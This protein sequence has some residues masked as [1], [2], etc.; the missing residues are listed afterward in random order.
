MYEELKKDDQQNLINFSSAT[1][2]FTFEGFF[3]IILTMIK[4]NQLFVFIF[5]TLFMFLFFGCNLPEKTTASNESQNKQAELLI[6]DLV[7]TA[8]AEDPYIPQAEGT[9]NEG[10]VVPDSPVSENPEAETP[11]IPSEPT[12]VPTPTRDPNRKPPELPAVFQTDLLHKLDTPHE[13]ESEICRV[14]KN[15]W[16]EGKAAPGTVVMAIMYH[17]IIRGEDTSSIS[18]PILRANTVTIDQHKQLIRNLHDQG[19]TAINTEQ[20]IAF[21]E[22]NEWI[23]ERSVLLIQDDRRHEDNFLEHFKPYYDEWGWQVINGWISAD[24][25]TQ[26]LWDENAR[27]EELGLVD[28][29][30][31]GVVHNINMG[32]DSSDEFLIGELKGSV[33][34]IQEHFHKT[35]RAIIWPGGGFGAR[36]IEIAKEYGYKVGFTTH[37]RGP[38]MYNWVPLC[39]VNDMGRPAYKMDGNMDPLFVIPRYWNTDASQHVDTVRQIGKAAQEYYYSIRETELEYYDIVCADE[40]GPL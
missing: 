8:Q 5:L 18:D 26:E 22:S 33:D 7:K 40:F 3:D 2:L 25:T 24:N 21:I 31:H 28:H 27:M 37:P 16:G 15:R 20:F 9:G 14:I 6:E 36:P 4:K 39:D 29:Q 23:P 34:R 32:D 11:E 30:S 10:S 17:S 12:A 19:F 38:V 35:P 1:I 13:Y